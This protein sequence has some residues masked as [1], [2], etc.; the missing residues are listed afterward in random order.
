MLSLIHL[1]WFFDGPPYIARDSWHMQ[2]S[3]FCD[4]DEPL[5]NDATR[6]LVKKG[7]QYQGH[8]MTLVEESA[9]TSLDYAK[10]LPALER[11]KY[12]KAFQ[13]FNSLFQ[14]RQTKHAEVPTTFVD[15]IR[16]KDVKL[17]KRKRR[18]L[19]LR[20]TLEEEEAE[21]RRRQRAES[22]EQA[23]LERHNVLSQSQI[24]VENPDPPSLQ[25]PNLS[26]QDLLD[27]P[28]FNSDG[29][30]HESEDNGS[31]DDVQY[32]RTQAMSH[33]AISP[34]SF[35]S[36]KSRH[37]S[38]NLTPSLKINDSDSDELVD[39]DKLLSQQ[40]PPP[41]VSLSQNLTTSQLPPSSAP[42][43]TR[44]ARGV[45]RK[46]TFELQRM[47]SQELKD[48]Q[49]KIEN[50]RQRLAKKEAANKRKQ[51]KAKQPR[52]EDILQLELL[53]RFAILSSSPAEED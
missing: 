31:N 44:T 47:E 36:R 35:S 3:D 52:K 50:K 27:R 41:L 13:E 28:E 46:K 6:T 39:I 9:V 43:M 15:P 11:E 53:N 38:R 25:G 37:S 16:P 19:S 17:K 14:N 18:G 30:E 34:S 22:I 23:R 2:Y 20:E 24:N 4:N 40:I 29:P 48:A 33:S 26:D 42:I 49:A 8:G 10:T 32:L 12:A 1:R 51:A 45:T 7:D 5:E 21:K